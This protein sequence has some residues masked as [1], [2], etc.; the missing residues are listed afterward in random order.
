MLSTGDSDDRL[1]VR[2][3]NSFNK[4]VNIFYFCPRILILLFYFSVGDSLEVYYRHWWRRCMLPR[5]K[6][7][8]L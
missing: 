8:T 1:L 7:S 3:T 5:V 2:E 4:L 6:K